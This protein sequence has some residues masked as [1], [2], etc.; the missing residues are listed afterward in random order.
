MTSTS[1]LL[2]L[3]EVFLPSANNAHAV[4]FHHV[5]SVA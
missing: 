3:I 1:G 4:C 5:S 2:A